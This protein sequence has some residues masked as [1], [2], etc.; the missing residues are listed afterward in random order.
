MATAI[1][2]IVLDL[3]TTA[4]KAAVCNKNLEFELFFSHPAPNITTNKGQYTSDTMAYL[5]ITEDLLKQCQPYCTSQPALGLCY[6]RSSL[7]IW[8]SHSGLPVTPLISW[9]DTRGESS[10]KELQ[11]HNSLI[12]QITGL[13]LTAYYFAP[14]VRLLLQQQPELRQGLL[15][16]DLRLG[17]LDSF[18]IWHWTAGKHYL[19]D[20]SMAA[21]TLL[22]DIHT[23]QWSNTL[24]NIF[25]I[26]LQTLPRIS[27]STSLDIDLINGMTLVTS[28]ADQ[29]AAFLASI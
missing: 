10:C 16:Q 22:M 24:S 14:K 8:N 7:L 21:R 15:N 29:S 13:P 20:V 5:A 25:D 23:A 18:L 9:Q 4:I 3:G 11:K 27:P 6:Q 19:M 26:P 17:T 28:V 1:N 12:K 2:T